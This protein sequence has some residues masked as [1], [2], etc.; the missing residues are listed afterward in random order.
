MAVPGVFIRVVDSVGPKA[1][2]KF[3]NGIWD[4]VGYDDSV[5]G[6]G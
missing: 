5:D 4:T 2:L 1:R 6:E 3:G